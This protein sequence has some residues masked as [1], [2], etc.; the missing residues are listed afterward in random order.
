MLKEIIFENKTPQESYKY[1]IKWLENINA[2]I[3][4]KDPPFEILA[5]HEKMHWV[6]ET[7]DRTGSSKSGPF[8]DWSKYLNIKIQ[9]GDSNTEIEFSILSPFFFFTKK[10]KNQIINNWIKLVGDFHVFLGND[11]DISQKR[12]YYRKE[13]FR[14]QLS[15]YLGVF[16]T[17]SLLL[18]ISLYVIL[19]IEN[20]LIAIVATLYLFYECIKSI[21]NIIKLNNLKK[22]IYPY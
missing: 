18:L 2:K 8:I 9:S 21:K 10:R 12:K 1:A 11:L 4:S 7:G 16:I 6:D 19:Y 22:Q 13:L 15:Y 20:G 3:I 5:L 14:N 17:H